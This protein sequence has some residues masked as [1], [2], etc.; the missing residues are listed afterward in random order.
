MCA[1]FLGRTSTLAPLNRGY[2]KGWLLFLLLSSGSLLAQSERE[3]F[4]QRQFVH[5]DSL[6]ALEQDRKLLEQSELLLTRLL[7]QE[8]SPYLGPLLFYQGVGLSF[9][10]KE[11][12]AVSAFERAKELIDAER[13]PNQS[14]N[15]DYY[16]ARSHYILGNQDLATAAL[17]RLLKRPALESNQ[18]LKAR[19]YYLLGELQRAAQNWSQGFPY[20]R[21][22]VAIA[23]EIG[24]STRWSAA[25][26]RIGV[27]HFNLENH[28]SARYYYQLTERLANF[29][30]GG[31]IH[32]MN[33]NDF[34]ELYFAL[35]DW[36]KAL[37][38]F[39]KALPYDQNSSSRV[40][41]LNNLSRL[42]LEI[43]SLAQA[44][45]FAHRA[46][47]LA[48]EQ[49]ILSLQVDALQ[50]LR[51]V[52]AQL[53][54]YQKATDYA[55][56][57]DRMRDSLY[58]ET[59]L[60]E[61]LRLEAE[62]DTERKEAQITQLQLEGKQREQGLQRATVLLLL[63]SI[64]LL[65]IGLLW[66]LNFYRHRRIE[67][68]SA[69]LKQLQALRDRLFSMVAHD[70]RSPVVALSGSQAKVDYYLRKQ[71]YDKLTGMGTKMEKSLQK[72]KELLQNL[73]LWALSQTEKI[74][75]KAEELALETL[76]SEGLSF[77]DQ[78]IQHKD[79]EVH[80]AIEPGL[81]LK[82]DPQTTAAALRNL[83]SN[84][85]KYS[86]EGGKISISARHNKTTNSV[87]ISVEDQGP[88]LKEDQIQALQKGLNVNQ[89]SES[90]A[91]GF[92]LG[93]ELTRDFAALNG[94]QLRV[95]SEEG[96]GSRFSLVFS[97]S[98]P[99]LGFRK[100]W[101]KSLVLLV[102]VP[103]SLWGQSARPTEEAQFR[104][105][106]SLVFEQPDQALALAEALLQK[107]DSIGPS[108][109]DW[110]RVQNYRGTAL[111]ILHQYAESI[112]VLRKARRALPDSLLR[113]A[114]ICRHNLSNSHYALG[115]Y[116]QAIAYLLENFSLDSSL[117]HPL[118]HSV[119]LAKLGEVHRAADNNDLALHY[120]RQAL[121]WSYRSDNHLRAIYCLD[122]IG[123]IKF[124]KHQHDSA[125]YYFLRALVELGEADEGL[126]VMIYNDLGMLYFTTGDYPRARE[127]YSQALRYARAEDER[128]SIWINTA[129]LWWQE[130]Q[131]DSA[132]AYSQKVQRYYRQDST[133]SLLKEAMRLMAESQ[134]KLGKHQEA[135]ATFSQYMKLKERLFEINRTQEIL[136]LS[137]AF[138]TERKEQELKN[139]AV[140]SAITQ[141]RSRTFLIAGGLTSLA[142]IFIFILVFRLR[143]TILVSRTKRAELQAQ[144]LSKD[145]F[146]SL[147]AHDL[148]QPVAQLQGSGRQVALLAK[149]EQW[150][151]MRDLAASL[152]R[153]M[154]TLSQRLD[155]L[156]YW[157]V[158]QN[159]ALPYQ[160]E[161]LSLD[162]LLQQ[163]LKSM[164]SRLPELKIKVHK[165][166]LASW[167][168]KVDYN[169]FQVVLR[170]LLKALLESEG[171][172]LIITSRE[173]SDSRILGLGREG[174]SSQRA[175]TLAQSWQSQAQELLSLN[176]EAILVQITLRLC[177]HNSIKLTS[178]VSEN[179]GFS[180]YLHFPK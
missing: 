42:A 150:Q 97:L 166:D 175:H 179:A 69:R 140:R 28:V 87:S 18:A 100:F 62:Y 137:Q 2:F 19:T 52:Y 68:I 40:N 33:Y 63:S 83:L 129:R 25:L 143:R 104:R 38:Y 80:T 157:A 64:S 125:E 114:L 145:R 92:G 43:D 79:L 49:H 5:L 94:A 164:A 9:T 124:N 8:Q 165:K 35:K 123:V 39:E 36:S 117:A 152:D 10:G 51:D 171:G 72:T 12:A 103:L 4:W 11:P 44:G 67:A 121:D 90:G 86:P 31:Q 154:E 160:E 88:G 174:L 24:D 151:A 41:N 14:L 46:L 93:L 71:R 130:G 3:S 158:Q 16:F 21:Q 115:E 172:D 149:Q 27:L 89:G 153:Q 178:T 34:G 101:E 180:F 161:S 45:E 126:L 127:A 1:N 132:L 73:L 7:D 29:P 20:L 76:L 74:E 26:N 78:T 22:A 6:I 155:N 112:E 85:V 48:T 91:G 66:G 173:T 122:R 54:D 84:A 141:S 105:L 136:R 177:E 59:K 108:R 144:V 110:A 113:E 81:I 15:N 96:R 156:L 57:Y 147:L 118:L 133:P 82:A 162:D 106:D 176:E 170:N 169:S 53:G 17:L 50:L 55:W 61:V 131:Y 65:I 13:W 134:R 167:Q 95:E 58:R 70:L 111:N 37:Y 135:L 109:S 107:L 159:T 138:E 148:S 32:A 98:R 47:S 146:F 128:T 60:G 56:E 75:L 142:A 99:A 119:T 102:F 30:G 23:K 163:S 139:L 77:F 168:L 116:P 120:L